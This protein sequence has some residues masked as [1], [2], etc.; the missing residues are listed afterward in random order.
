M[1]KDQTDDTSVWSIFLSVHLFR[2]ADVTYTRQHFTYLALTLLPDRWVVFII[3]V[4]IIRQQYQIFSPQHWCATESESGFDFDW[5]HH[6]L[7]SKTF[8]A[9]TDALKVYVLAHCCSCCVIFTFWSCISCCPSG[10]KSFLAL[11]NKSFM[12]AV[13]L[14]GTSSHQNR[15]HVKLSSC[16]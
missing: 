5:F 14:V 16:K 1:C 15:K 7:S 6:V 11:T 8:V 10:A 12:L 9:L 4:Y 2:A 13:Y 3:C